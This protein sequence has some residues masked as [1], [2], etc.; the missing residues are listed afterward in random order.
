MIT[1]IRSAATGAI[2]IF[3]ADTE[4]STIE[5]AQ[6]HADTY[7]RVAWRSSTEALANEQA[8]HLCR[9]SM[10][11]PLEAR[12]RHPE[13]IC[14]VCALDAVDAQGRRVCFGNAGPGGGFRGWYADTLAPY[15]RHDCI[16]RGVPCRA[17]EARFGGI[18]IEP[19]GKA[20]RP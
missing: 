10:G 1:L 20:T 2:R 19:R 6:A 14:Q 9:C 13:R 8:C 17:D 12:E 18:V 15:D 4:Y 11:K 7:G 16:I 5:E 3:G